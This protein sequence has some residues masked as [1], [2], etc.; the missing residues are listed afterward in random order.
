MT[1]DELKMSQMIEESIMCPIE[2]LKSKAKVTNP[3][4]TVRKLRRFE[5]IIDEDKPSV[6]YVPE[7]IDKIISPGFV[8]VMPKGEL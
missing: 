3:Q 5:C 7:E 2:S 6:L 4:K 1:N 8:V